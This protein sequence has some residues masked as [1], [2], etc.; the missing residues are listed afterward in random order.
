LIASSGYNYALANSGY[1][2]NYHCYRNGIER[3]LP[4]SQVP[5]VPNFDSGKKQVGESAPADSSHPQSQE[6]VGLGCSKDLL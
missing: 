5:N 4:A 1:I 3:R 2:T 6:A